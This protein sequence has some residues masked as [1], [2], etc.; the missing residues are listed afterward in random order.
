MVRLCGLHRGGAAGSLQPPARPGRTRQV[1]HS[2]GSAAGPE[3]QQRGQRG[4][5]PLAG[6]HDPA[7]QQRGFAGGWILS[8]GQRQR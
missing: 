7:L 6:P 4:G 8:P 2:Q 3:L 1:L 5:G